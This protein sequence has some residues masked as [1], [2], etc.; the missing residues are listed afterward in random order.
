MHRMIKG[1]WLT[2]LAVGLVVTTLIAPVAGAVVEP[3]QQDAFGAVDAFIRSEMGRHRI[4]GLALAITK[5]DEIVHVKGFGTAGGQRTVTADTPF[6]IGS[7][8]KSFTALAVMQLVE[9]G[10]VELDAPVQRYIPW[11]AVADEEASR[12]ITVRH[13]LHHTSGLSDAGYRRGMPPADATLEET[14][15]DLRRAELTAPVG[16]THQYFNLNYNVLGVI[17]QEVSGQS[18]SVYVEEHIFRP[19]DMENSYVS[20]AAAEQAGLAQGHNVLLGFPVARQQPHLSYDLPAGMIIASAKDMARYTIAQNNGGCLGDTCILSAEAVKE[21]HT[22]PEGVDTSYAMGWEVRREDGARRVSHNGAVR[23]FFSSVTLLPDEGYGVVVLV[24]QNGLFHLLM[25]YERVVDGVVD[26]LLGREPSGGIAMATL[27][28]AIGVVMA[29]DLGR[30]GLSLARLPGQRQ[31]WE[32]R[33][34]GRRVAGLALQ[35]LLALVVLVG[36]PLLLMTQAGTDATRVMLF[37]YA[38][39]IAAWLAVSSV[40]TLVE[41]G[42]KARWMLA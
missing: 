23:T 17:I 4:P 37:N 19:L 25:A 15:R 9:A 20:K 42:I 10:E 16:I 11:F 14:V 24:N 18:Y 5:G 28:A 41:A 3:A 22:P 26:L 21:M 2:A 31:R 39:G 1:W 32:G 7:V 33:P 36:G 35:A 34:P 8:S 38:P 13:L 30:R 29:V 27:Y 40:L 6:F 12:A